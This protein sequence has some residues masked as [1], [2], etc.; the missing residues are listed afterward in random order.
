MFLILKI[1]SLCNFKCDYCSASCLSK[2]ANPHITFDD[3]KRLMETYD[4]DGISIV[5]GDP[6][7]APPSLYLQMLQ[8]AI[9]RLQ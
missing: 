2:E 6:L 8:T 5:G 1:T 3:F 4:V 7:C 9:R